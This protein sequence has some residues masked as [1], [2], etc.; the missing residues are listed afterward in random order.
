MVKCHV[1]GAS[2]FRSSHFRRPD[3][4]RLIRL[5]LPVRCRV[6]HARQYA[7]IRQAL[8][9]KGAD[10]ARHARMR[11]RQLAREAAGRAPGKPAT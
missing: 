9:I 3:I 7:W 11:A 1:C 2:D 6:C 4:K 10:R 5:E 8:R